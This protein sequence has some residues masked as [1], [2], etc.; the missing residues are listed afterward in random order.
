[1]SQNLKFTK[2]HANIA[3]RL[4]IQHHKRRPWILRKR[5][6]FWISFVR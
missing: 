5:F 3:S 4:N 6:D 2:S 1:M